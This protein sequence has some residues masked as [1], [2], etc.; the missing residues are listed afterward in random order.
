[1]LLGSGAL[2]TSY[3]IRLRGVEH[4]LIFYRLVGG[5]EGRIVDGKEGE[6]RGDHRIRVAFRHRITRVCNSHSSRRIEAVAE[7]ANEGQMMLTSRGGLSISLEVLRSHLKLPRLVWSQR[8]SLCEGPVPM[9]S[10]GM[11]L[12]Y[13][14][15]H[16]DST[17]PSLTIRSEFSSAAPTNSVLPP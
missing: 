2:G 11:H 13:K 17:P 10:A 4:D 16:T 1:M 14:D 3:I 8:C 15:L 12:L 5:T 6:L 9:V 7:E